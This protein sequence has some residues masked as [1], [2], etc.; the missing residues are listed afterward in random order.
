MAE[1]LTAVCDTALPEGRVPEWV[2]LIPDLYGTLKTRDGRTFMMDDP[3]GLIADFRERAVDLP[4]DYEHQN[5]NPEAKA[6]GAIPAAG[7]I[8]DLKEEPDGIWGRVEWT[9]AAREMIGRKEYR[10]ISPA[11]LVEKGS[12]RIVRIKGAGLVHNPNLPLVALSSEATPPATRSQGAG[13]DDAALLVR[14][15]AALGLPADAGLDL[16][17]A[18][19]IRVAKVIARLAGNA[20]A[21]TA[22][23]REASAKSPMP[24]GPMEVL[25]SLLEETRRERRE[26]KEGQAQE[27]VRAALAKGYITP[28]MKDWA[29]ALCRSDEAAF[30]TFLEKSGPVFGELLRETHT[31]GVPRWSS[32]A[33]APGA[34]AGE[35]ETAICSQLG[36]AP[37]R[38]ST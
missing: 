23:Q 20:P 24:G 1:L 11:L 5:D 30:D 4:V 9:A 22:A 2:Q 32:A 8:K 34:R 35:V 13:N 27:K 25:T 36:L 18:E 10:Y 3:E 28:A 21:E 37:G 38:L 33:E 26:L 7:W 31:K 29:V 16:V 19:Y 12:N 14:L 6:R 15:R 17:A